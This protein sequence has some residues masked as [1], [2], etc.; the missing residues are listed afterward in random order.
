MMEGDQEV[1]I[2]SEEAELLEAKE[3]F[4][5][6]KK[7]YRLT[8]NPLLKKTMTLMTHSLHSRVRLLTFR[9]KRLNMT[10]KKKHPRVQVKGKNPRMKTSLRST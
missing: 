8:D 4:L 7:E 10:I 5:L 3:I 6:M 1:P 9:R 2:V